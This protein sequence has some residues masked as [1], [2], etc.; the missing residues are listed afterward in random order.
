MLTACLISAPAA[1]AISKL[2]YPE[3]EKVDFNKQ[4]NICM[5]D[6][7]SPRT[8]MQAISDGATF[9][10]KLIATIMVNMMAFVSI[11]NLVDTLLIWCGERA[12][13]EDFSFNY[14]SSYVFYHL[15]WI[16]G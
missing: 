13:K 10:I 8:G 14:V 11:L 15:S 1:L 9:S 4:R 6:A 5:R 2:I 16:M 3:M 7:S 12:G